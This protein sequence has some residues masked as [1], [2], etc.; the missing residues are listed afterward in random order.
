MKS[1]YKPSYGELLREAEERLR[2]A[3]VPEAQLDAWYILSD[4][5]GISRA[6]YLWKRD[7]GP[8]RIPDIWEER[9]EG[10][11]RRIPLAYLLGETEFMGL[12]F[13]VRPG[14]LIPRQDT[15]TL[16]SE[17]AKTVQNTPREKL[18]FFEKLKG[19]K[20]RR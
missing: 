9:I 8:E 2:E 18:S 1:A 5:F 6:E 17:A 20:D 16:V 10:R 13:Y 14:V 4:T 7:A 19:R 15:E 12:P 11:C 3:G